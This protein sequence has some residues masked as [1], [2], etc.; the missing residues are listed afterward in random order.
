[1]RTET[2]AIPALISVHDVMPET[3]PQV[4]ELLA[5]LSGR[6]LLPVTLL[7]IPGKAWTQQQIDELH[8][9]EGQGM[10]LA[11]H[12]WNH[13]ITHIK[14]LYHRLHSALVSREAGEHLSLNR[15]QLHNLIARCFNWFEERRL[16]PPDLY[17]PPAWAMGPLSR[18]DLRRLPFRRYETLRGVYDSLT[19]GYTR[20]PLVGFEAS[21]AWR[22]PLLRLWN[23]FNLQASRTPRPVRIGIHPDDLALPLARDLIRLLDRPL[24]CRSYRELDQATFD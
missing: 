18:T 20:L 16:G 7:V 24:D 10:I 13:R 15:Q 14:G 17:V 3:L 1:M 22:A 2:D 6:N 4:R 9:F 8:E 19:Q 12:G 21:S 11:G 5:V 23:G